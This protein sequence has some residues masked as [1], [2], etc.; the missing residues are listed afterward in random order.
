MPVEPLA[1]TPI[2]KLRQVMALLNEVR[3]VGV[4]KGSGD[5]YFRGLGDGSRLMGARDYLR[6][7]LILIV[8]IAVTAWLAIGARI[9]R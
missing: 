7:L 6:F 4:P 3:V 2:R 8:V 9:L 5:I 1:T